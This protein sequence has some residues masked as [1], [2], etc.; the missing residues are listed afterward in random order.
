MKQAVSI[1]MVILLV[2][3]AS[4]C[5]NTAEPSDSDTEFGY[6]ELVYGGTWGVYR[7]VYDPTTMV[8]YCMSNGGYNSG[9]LS[10]IYDDDG[11][12]LT[13]DEYMEKEKVVKEV[14]P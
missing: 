8:M 9:N 4:A 12:L 2:I 7:I 6:F 1:L 14:S 13:Y 5:G 10:P 11:T 3:I